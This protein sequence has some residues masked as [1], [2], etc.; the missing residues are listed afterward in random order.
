MASHGDDTRGHVT[1]AIDVSPDAVDAGA[2]MA[3]R[4][5]VSC[6][7]PCD[8]RGHTLLIKDGAG[9]DAGSVEIV[10]FDGEINSTN[11]FVLVAP[12]VPG[13]HTWS[14]VC[15]AVERGGTS[16]IE[17]STPMS[18]TVTPHATH[19][20]AW[21]IPSDIVVGE[22][23][24]MKVGVKCSSG[25]D[26]ANSDFGIYDHEGNKVAAAVLS[27]ERWPETAGLHVAEV[28]LEAPAS[29]GLHT[30]SVK[31]P[32]SGLELPHA[33]GAVDFGVNVVGHPECLVTIEAVDTVTQTPLSGARV[34]MHPYRVVADEHGVARVRVAKGA[35]RLFVSQ[36]NY[37]TFGLA[38][39]VDADMT[40]RAELEPEPVLERN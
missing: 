26:L 25:C 18:F 14:V 22:R 2:E 11:E 10:E 4:V 35:Y 3:L 36:T 30:W 9:A 40:S 1:C 6:S 24:R 21:D 28:E 34:V 37:L 15:P 23:F 29:E 33:E 17:A 5:D 31:H 13:A 39:D 8:L 7:P 20:V 38:V 16:Y 32:Q 19:I 27:D 12:A